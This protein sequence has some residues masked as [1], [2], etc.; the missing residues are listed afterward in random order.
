MSANLNQELLTTLR[1]LRDELINAHRPIVLKREDAPGQYVFHISRGISDSVQ[2][3]VTLHEVRNV[4]GAR[5]L[6]RPC[7]EAAFRV[8]AVRKVPVTLYRIAHT[9]WKEDLKFLEAAAANGNKVDLP[10]HQE[11]WANQKALFAKSFA[12]K[13]LSEEYVSAYQLAEIGGWQKVYSFQYRLYCN[14]THASLR[15]IM[16]WPEHMPTLDLITVGACAVV[17]LEAARDLG[18]PAHRLAELRDRL[19]ELTKKANIDENDSK[20]AGKTPPAR[21]A[22]HR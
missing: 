17:A 1:E 10:I 22:T 5:I 6:V 13:K 12:G 3:Y 8:A 16:G 9:E 7:I 11:K 21:H 15:S 14:F 4:M 19:N 18:G 20:D 2:A